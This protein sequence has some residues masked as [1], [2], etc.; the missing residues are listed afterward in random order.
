LFSHSRLSR[1]TYSMQRV[2][3]LILIAIVLMSALPSAFATDY[4][5]ASFKVSN[6]VIEELGGISNSTSFRLLGSIPFIEPRRSTS[7]SYINIPAFPAFPGSTTTVST[8]TPPTGGGGGGG[9]G[10]APD[11]SKP[12]PKL[13]DKNFLRVDFN[14]DGFVNFID[15]SILLYYFDKTGSIII[16]FDLNEDGLVDMVDISIFMYYWDGK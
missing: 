6:P 7:T 13:T 9:G 3:I 16:P 5:S 10:V 8:A 15:F 2:T 11:P 12:K 14:R 1:Y 4:S